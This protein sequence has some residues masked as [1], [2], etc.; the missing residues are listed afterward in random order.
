MVGSILHVNTSSVRLGRFSLTQ[1][2]RGI[3]RV[4]GCHVT[5][6]EAMSRES[7]T[8][9]AGDAFDRDS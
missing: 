4:L 9:F 1:F 5:P 2:P 8:D 7:P 3:S 6:G